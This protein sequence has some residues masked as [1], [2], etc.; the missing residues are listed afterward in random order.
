VNAA[1]TAM[2]WSGVSAAATDRDH[3]HNLWEWPPAG[4]FSFHVVDIGNIVE[5]FLNLPA[6]YLQFIRA[7]GQ[8]LQKFDRHVGQTRQSGTSFLSF[9]PFDCRRALANP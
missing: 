7:E 3:S 2:S 1:Q 4:P 6:D 8:T 9:A 5:A